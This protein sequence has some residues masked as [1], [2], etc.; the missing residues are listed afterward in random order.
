MLDYRPVVMTPATTTRKWAVG[1]VAAWLMFAFGGLFI[2]T[3][4]SV[5]AVADVVIAVASGLAGGIASWFAIFR[6]GDR[7]I[8][9]RAAA[10]VLILSI[11]LILVHPL[12][13]GD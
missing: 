6:A 11:L 1:L 4:D 9:V 8:I 10:I 5:W 12:S 2:A 7:A 13:I 3:G